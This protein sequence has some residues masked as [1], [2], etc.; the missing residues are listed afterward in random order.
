M[1]KCMNVCV[2]MGACVRV[3]T[4]IYLNLCLIIRLTDGLENQP[5]FKAGSFLFN[6][7]GAN[8]INL[9]LSLARWIGNET[10]KI[11]VK[12]L[13]ILMIR[14]SELQ[15]GM[16]RVHLRCFLI[17]ITSPSLLTIGYSCKRHQNPWHFVIKAV[18]AVYKS[19]KITIGWT[20][21]KV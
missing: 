6:W 13:M 7:A 17:C 8:L 3:C 5:K 19:Q 1:C 21:L 14:R 18:T 20:R 16:Y 11:P 15:R 2:C 4:Y 9:T 12:C 10:T